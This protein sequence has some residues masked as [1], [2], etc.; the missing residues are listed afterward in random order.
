MDFQLLMA[1]DDGVIDDILSSW[2]TLSDL[3][4]G[5]DVAVTSAAYREMYLKHLYNANITLHQPLTIYPE[6]E[7]VREVTVKG[8]K[9][10]KTAP[11][12]ETD[13]DAESAPSSSSSNNLFYWLYHRNFAVENIEFQ[14]SIELTDLQYIDQR[15][16]NRIETLRF[17]G[18]VLTEL[19][20]HCVMQCPHLKHLTI[21]CWINST[22]TDDLIV[23]IIQHC[24]ELES[25]EL[26]QCQAIT[27]KT[28][29]A[30]HAMHA[31]RRT[32]YSAGSTTAI[33]GK[34]FQRLKM[35][36]CTNVV[37]A[38]PQQCLHLLGWIPQL[39]VTDS[40]AFH[41]QSSH[42]IQPNAQTVLY[43]S[44]K[45]IAMDIQPLSLIAVSCPNIEKLTIVIGDQHLGNA[46]QDHLISVA[47][48]FLRVQE[49]SLV[50]KCKNFD[51][52]LLSI[53]F[54]ATPESS[55]SHIRKIVV[56][57]HAA[58]PHDCV[59]IELLTSLLKH[60]P[61]LTS[62]T[63]HNALYARESEQNLQA[64]DEE[65][66][67]EEDGFEDMSDTEF[68]EED[69]DFV[70]TEDE[71][72]TP[73]DPSASAS[74]ASS[75][76]AS[77]TSV[78]ETE[79][80][81]RRESLVELELINSHNVT[82]AIVAR[83]PELFPNLRI[84]NLTMCRNISTQALYTISRSFHALTHLYLSHSDQVTSD[85]AI[86]FLQSNPALEELDLSRCPCLSDDLLLYLLQTDHN[87]RTLKRLD[88]SMKGDLSLRL[89]QSLLERRY[90]NKLWPLK[91]ISVDSMEKKE[92]EAL[93]TKLRQLTKAAN[94]LEPI[95]HLDVIL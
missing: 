8:H 12:L 31:G 82:D 30:L 7:R 79:T 58:T 83:L 13:T 80:S 50:N 52:T 86:G 57:S 90:A 71:Q 70:G 78:S 73:M 23:R 55:R 19:D 93:M 49:V 91:H 59:N 46:V 66:E 15:M 16:V 48:A 6:P 35:H 32:T 21:D 5:L 64:M 77:T 53:Y 43:P 42:S 10:R 36:L 62:L 20:V 47:N 63:L 44:V 88:I 22:V 72:D 85:V 76:N 37:F 17:T 61:N 25:L 3:A 69:T 94:L 41:Q 27:V 39:S 95:L 28:L 51:R 81:T 45:S 60:F 56:E 87:I 1:L 4:L 38:D 92:A 89:L 9:K 24:R 40:V 65:D 18:N 67:D 54:L 75:A 84:L 68:A 2:L 26:I 74:A 11:A 34:G 33:Q 14:R 29:E